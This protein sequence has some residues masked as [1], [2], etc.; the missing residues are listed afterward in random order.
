VKE[1]YDLGIRA[2]NI[3][4]KVSEDLKTIQ[5][6]KLGTLVNARRDSCYKM[7]VLR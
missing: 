6:K 1:L 3:Y 5:E 7:L 2:V 4:V